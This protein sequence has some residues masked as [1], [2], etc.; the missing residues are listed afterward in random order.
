MQ[1]QALVRA[2]LESAIDSGLVEN[3]GGVVLR[4]QPNVDN[5]RTPLDLRV[6]PPSHHL[7]GNARAARGTNEHQEDQQQGWSFASSIRNLL[8]SK[9]EVNAV[10]SSQKEIDWNWDWS[11]FW[12]WCWWPM[13]AVFT[14]LGVVGVMQILP[15]AG[16]LPIAFATTGATSW[17]SSIVAGVSMAAS[18]ASIVAPLVA[19]VY[20]WSH[21]DYIKWMCIIGIVILFLPTI[22]R[23]GKLLH[24]GSVLTFGT[25]MRLL[26]SFLQRK[27]SA[28]MEDPSHSGRDASSCKIR[29]LHEEQGDAFFKSRKSIDDEDAMSGSGSR[30]SL[31]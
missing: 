23:L 16:A 19:T 25:S 8:L 28:C 24:A 22:L 30:V 29:P 14:V 11:M 20:I 1:L 2:A 17:V 12:D 6:L 3:H 5:P 27:D 26:Q 10:A 4:L 7:D 15:S 31:D 18:S 13:I 21:W 9:D